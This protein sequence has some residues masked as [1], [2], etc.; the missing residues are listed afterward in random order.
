M[1]YSTETFFSMVEMERWIKYFDG[2]LVTIVDNEALLGHQTK[3]L[4]VYMD[5]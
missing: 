2:V 4:V 1:K 5:E 3:Y